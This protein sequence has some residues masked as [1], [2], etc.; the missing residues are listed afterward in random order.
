[1]NKKME[2]AAYDVYRFIQIMT[3]FSVF[4]LNHLVVQ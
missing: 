4:N 2:D 1:V 3:A